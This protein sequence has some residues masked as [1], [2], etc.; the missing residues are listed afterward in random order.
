M[1]VFTPG[2]NS[3]IDDISVKLLKKRSVSEPETEVSPSP[4][5]TTTEGKIDV[6]VISKTWNNAMSQWNS[7]FIVKKTVFQFA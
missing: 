7:S 1:Q 3:L 6:S 2:K 5:P 4:A